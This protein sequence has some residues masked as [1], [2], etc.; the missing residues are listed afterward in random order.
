MI[1]LQKY[2]RFILTL[3]A[4]LYLLPGI[5]Q[6]PLLDRDESRF[7]RATVEMMERGDWVVPYFNNNYRFDK[8]PLTYWWMSLD[9]RLFGVTELG[10]RFHS[11]VATWLVALIVFSLGRRLDL[12]VQWS[13]LAGLVWLT[14][15]QVWIHGRLALADAPLLLGLT[16]AMRAIAEYLFSGQPLPRFGRWFWC[17][18]LGIAFGFLAKGPLA[19]LIPPLG[20]ALFFAFADSDLRR[21]AQVRALRNSLLPGVPLVLLLIGLWGIPALL[22]TDGAFFNV[23]IGEHVVERG[24][25]SFNERLFIPGLYY[26]VAILIFFSPWVAVLWPSL[27]TGWLERKK[28]ASDWFLVSWALSSLLIFSFYKTQLPHYI[29]PAYPAL[30]ILAA[31]CLYRQRLPNFQLTVW[32]NRFLLGAFCLAGLCLGTVLWPREILRSLPLCL[33]L[34]GLFFGLLLFASEAVR[35]QRFSLVFFA[36]TLAALLFLPIALS[37]RNAHITVAAKAAFGDQWNQAE[38]ALGIGFTEPSLVWYADRYWNFDHGQSLESLDLTPERILIFRT[39]RW[40]LDEDMVL[41]WFR[42]E[43]VQP[44]HDRREQLKDQFPEHQIE[45]VQGFSPGNSSWIEI[46]LVSTETQIN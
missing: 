33:M 25:K 42:K 5:A 29:L 21:S 38:E 32:I 13:L 30:A 4:V 12:P 14:S 46:A 31:R 1:F 35:R 39:R 18:Y 7:S 36:V 19:F 23:G 16:L 6:L 11:V 24:V 15:L 41:A 10:A 27:R 43:A 26:L 20:L 45:F 44:L 28:E 22:Q 17:L 3:V 40:R 9:Y 2:P 37:F 8:P 34:L